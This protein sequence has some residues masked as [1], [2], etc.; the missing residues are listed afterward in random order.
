MN[1]V[2][3]ERGPGPEIAGTRITVYDIWDYAKEGMHGDAIAAAL[4][5]SSNQVQ[6]A[7]EYIDRHKEEVLAE[8]QIMLD[9]DARGNPPDVQDKL[10]R[11]HAKYQA[12]WQNEKQRIPEI[13]G[14]RDSGGQ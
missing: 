11:T 3:I 9:R 1:D 8:Y 13:D 12:L 14:E 4:R 7:L 5:L 10:E 6:A 2:I